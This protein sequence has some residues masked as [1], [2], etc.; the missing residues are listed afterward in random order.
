[1]DLQ[2]TQKQ[3]ITNKG[4]S[5]NASNQSDDQRDK[6]IQAFKKAT[7]E[8]AKDDDSL[9]ESSSDEAEDDDDDEPQQKKKV[10]QKQQPKGSYNVKKESDALSNPL[11]D[12]DDEGA[13]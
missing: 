12:S 1:M 6:M 5:H 9:V 3:G 2:E 13:K 7:L 11:D 10:A 4:S 8:E